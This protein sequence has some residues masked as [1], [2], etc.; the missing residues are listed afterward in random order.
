M[1][2]KFKFF[3]IV[4]FKILTIIFLISAIGAFITSIIYHIKNDS[5]DIGFIIFSNLSVTFF[6]RIATALFFYVFAIFVN[7]WLKIDEE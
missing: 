5:E 6:Y 3:V 1:N 2:E 4:L 7:D